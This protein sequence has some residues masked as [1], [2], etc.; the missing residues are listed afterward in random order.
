MYIDCEGVVGWHG[1]GEVV[2]CFPRGTRCGRRGPPEGST[3]RG[4]SSSPS[5]DRN[6][7]DG[8]GF[9]FFLFDNDGDEFVCRCLYLPLCLSIS[10]LSP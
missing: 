3:D 2:V 4:G 5:L 9:F 1:A 8:F 7:R 6:T 10:L